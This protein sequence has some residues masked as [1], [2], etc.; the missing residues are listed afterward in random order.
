MPMRAIGTYL[1][2]FAYPYPFFTGRLVWFMWVVNF[3]GGGF[4]VPSLTQ[5]KSD[6]NLPLTLTRV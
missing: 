2:F 5:A 1:D 4:G 3:R 6:P